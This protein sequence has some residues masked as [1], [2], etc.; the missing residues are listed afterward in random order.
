MTERSGDLGDFVYILLRRRKF[1]FWNTFVVTVLVMGGSFL[2][3][4]RFTATATLLPP[5]EELGSSL[6]EMASL[7]QN[8]DLSNVPIPGVTSSAQV[9]L[10]ILHSRT[11]AD[12]LIVEFDLM[13][14]YKVKNMELARRALRA[15]TDCDLAS[16]GLIRIS[17]EDKNSQVAANMANAFARHLDRINRDLRMSEG[18]RTRIFIE[19]RIEATRE[20]LHAAEDSLLAF[21]RSNPGVF[22]LTESSSA[23]AGADL[24]ARRIS[25]GAELEMLR[26][27]FHSDAPVLNRKKQ[28]AE[29]LDHELEN[30]P[31]AELELARRY[32]DVKIQERVFEFLTSQFE[33]A[34]IQ[35][36]KDVATVE[37]LDPAVPPIRKSFPRRGIMTVLAFLLSIVVGAVAVISQ[38]ALAALRVRDDVRLRR[39]L[40]PGSLLDRLLFGWRSEPSS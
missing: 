30:L 36:N 21:R 5:K 35:E 31:A 40:K 6:L 10:A 25:V 17:V 12:S 19:R 28:E 8:F 23:E 4:L 37:V 1:L 15:A 29:A 11:V 22:L 33:Q 14:R 3:P 32:R 18:K 38:E 13:H 20:R 24:M 7:A 2:L 34:Q 16:A 9:Y 26:N 39:V 27:S